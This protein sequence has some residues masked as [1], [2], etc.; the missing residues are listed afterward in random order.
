[1]AKFNDPRRTLAEKTPSHEEVW[2]AIRYLD[3]EMK[4]KADTRDAIIAL[5]AALLIIC[6]TVL[7]L[8]LIGL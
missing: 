6:V 5:A 3:F 8:R 4:D 7:G 1:M 2:S